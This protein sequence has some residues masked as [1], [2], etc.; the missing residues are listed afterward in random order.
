ML[1]RTATPLAA[2]LALGVGLGLPAGALAG[3][4]TGGTSAPD[5][6]VSTGASAPVASAGNG[7][8]K[9]G[10]AALLG[11]W[12][13]IAGTLDGAGSGQAL[14][15]QLSDGR[16]GWT[17]VSRGVAGKGGTFSARWRPRRTG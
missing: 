10:R 12:Q 16:T 4:P 7:S 9:A 11:R 17:T 15:V 3:D 14:I 2:V 5:P 1:P 6:S 13:R 8:L